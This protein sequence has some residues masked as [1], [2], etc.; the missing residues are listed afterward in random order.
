MPTVS[1]EAPWGGQMQNPSSIPSLVTKFKELWA[2]SEAL[3]VSCTRRVLE[4]MSYRMYPT[5]PC[6]PCGRDHVC[7]ES[8][9]NPDTQSQALTDVFPRV[10]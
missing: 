9:L 3:S 10:N 4:R 7:A 8:T 5:R 2:A 6:V 1:R